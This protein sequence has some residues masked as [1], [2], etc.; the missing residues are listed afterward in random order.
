[1]DSMEEFQPFN[2]RMHPWAADPKTIGALAG[3]QL[4]IISSVGSAG[5]AADEPQQ[6]ARHQELNEEI[7]KAGAIPKFKNFLESGAVDRLHTA[8]VALSF[9]S[10]D[11]HACAQEML[12]IDM[13]PILIPHLKSPKQGMRAAVATTLRN[14]S[15]VSN[16]AREKLADAGGLTEMVKQLELDEDNADLK[17][18]AILNLQDILEEEDG[19]I[20]E[21]VAKVFKF[22][23]NVMD[24]LKATVDKEDSADE[25]EMD[26]NNQAEELL[27]KLEAVEE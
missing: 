26:V 8:V 22:K 15:C 25:V 16:E 23:T 4:A 5:E 2:D 27:E 17:L 24:L 10:T 13:M 12:Q 9:M 19:P 1:M 14:I 21:K 18:E 20:N 6:V 11:N 7:R 3:T